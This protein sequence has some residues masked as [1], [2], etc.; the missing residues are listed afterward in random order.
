MPGAHL[1]GAVA[2]VQ[3]R[4]GSTRLPGKVMRELCGVTILGHV[5]QRVARCPRVGKVVVATTESERDSIIVAEAARHGAG[6]TRGSEEDVLARYY[7]AATEHH[8]DPIV[9]VT[10]DCP[11]F[12]P[13]LLTSMLEAY[14]RES[15]QPEGVD[16]LSNTV[17]RT[18]P[19]GLDA[20]I[21]AFGA[22]ERAHRE[23][24]APFEREH[25]TP[26]I[27]Q[28]PG[29]FRVRHFLGDED[30]SSHR[31]TLDTE[32]DWKLIRAVFEHLC[33]RD[34]AFTTR[35]VLALLAARPELTALNAHVRQK[36]AKR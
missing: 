29:L 9:R 31:W 35:E 18:F 6:V 10:S 14:G 23:A 5:I 26:Y 1:S 34:G 33:V 25:V 21:I 16:Y 17:R 36:E 2:I 27:W 20:E 22:L 15:A 32:D 7:Q 4:M 13:D 24:I 11:L 30:L 12:D 19:R 8:A 28:H 3:A